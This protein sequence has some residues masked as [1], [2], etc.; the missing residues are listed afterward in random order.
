MGACRAGLTMVAAV[1][2]FCQ[3]VLAQPAGPAAAQPGSAQGKIVALN[4]RVEHTPAP[5]EQWNNARMFQP[6]LVAERVRTMTASRASILFIDETQVKLNA[7]AVLTVREVR[8]AGGAGTS[9]ELSKGE[10]WFRTKNPASGLTIQTPAAAAAVRGTEINLRVG[11]DNL[12]TLTVVEGSTEFSNAQG[13]IIVNAGEEG[14]ALPGQAPTK[15]VIL[16]PENA[17]QWALYY[18]AQVAWRDLPAA[19][20][21]GPAAAGFERLRAGDPTGALQIFQAPADTWSRIGASIAYLDAGDITQARTVL[22]QP[23]SGTSEQAEWRAQLASVHLATGDIASARREIDAALAQDPNALRPLVLLSSVELRQN[24]PDRAQAAADRA[25]AAHP[26]SVGALVAASEA[27]QS[28]FDLA[29]ARRHL[30]R[31]IALDGRDVH[32]LVNRARIRFGT[33]DIVGAREDAERAAAVAPNDAQVRSLR[34][35]INLSEGNVAAARTDFEAAAQA[36]T[37]FGEPHL[38]LGLAHFRAGRVDDGLLEMLT[39]TLLEPQVALYQSYLG[40]AYYQA[41]RFTEGLSALASAKRLDPRDP[42]PWLYSSLYLR[43]QNRQVDA[44]NELRHAI[45]LNDHRAVYRGRLLLDRDL[46]TKNVSLAE[47]YRQLGFEAWGAYEA[48]NSLE[49]DVT[50]AS[51]HLFLAESYNSLPD[52]NEAAGSEL[53]QYFLYAP[54]NRNSFN[55]FA[56][57]TALLEQPRRQFTVTAETGSRERAN[58]TVNHRF[59]NERYAHVAFFDAAQQTG[60]RLG[61]DDDRTQAFYQ[62]KL[63]LRRLTDMFFSFSAVKDETGASDVSTLNF[64]LETATPVILRQ[65]TSSPDSSITNRFTNRELTLG[66]KHQWHPGAVF[67]ASARHEEFETTV[68]RPQGTTSDCFGF[69]LTPFGARSSNARR[70]N[71]FESM[72]LQVQQTARL[73]RHQFLAGHQR[74]KVN[75]ARHCTELVTFA[76]GSAEQAVTDATS[77]D[78]AHITYARDEIQLTRWLH[79]SLGIAYQDV[80]FQDPGD[81]EVLDVDQ[82]SP[83]VGISARVAPSTFIRAAAYRDLHTNITGAN[84]APPTVAGFA[85]ARNS[86]PTAK[87]NEYDVSVEHSGGRAFVAVHGFRRESTVPSLLV[88]GQS[89]IPDADASGIGTS[90]YV[91]WIASRRVTVFGDNQLIRFAARAFDRVDNLAR[92]GV[93]LI[94]PRGVFLRVTGSHIS[95]RFSDS[96]VTNLPRS[97]FVLADVEANYEF[98]GKRGLASL[99]VTNVFDRDFAAVVEGVSVDLFRPGRR[100][101]L[102]LRWRLW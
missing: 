64:G 36:D 26:E 52:R 11:P 91:N 69:D 83:R 63:S 20:S 73:G 78:R 8:R 42:T 39:A 49:L 35:F 88:D 79:A 41:E 56:E 23:P 15:R 13:S 45:A 84:I 34:G 46:A 30:D 28:R 4:G 101:I 17:V 9:L 71:P 51:A 29:A 97:N 12:T 65:F 96:L 22:G 100:A 16:N 87:R 21:A 75:K 50:N 95:Q 33:D 5:A 62:G 55:S 76:D 90:V 98:A 32:A 74:L 37:E 14:T 1:F 38:G 67:T 10:G 54:V 48:L 60:P 7:D 102:S 31:A 58:G 92:V 82:W 47:I 19:A 68:E 53:I 66:I 80:E 61:S 93:N 43:D 40:K 24:Q 57:Y 18:P 44:L 89:F 72:N 2:S 77:D 99:A 86:F 70:L 59:G 6:L 94:H 81:A 3:P 85:I 27:A 25:L